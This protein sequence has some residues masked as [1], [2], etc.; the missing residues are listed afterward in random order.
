MPKKYE[1]QC[2]KQYIKLRKIMDMTQID[3]AEITGISLQTIRSYESGR[4]NPSVINME[5]MARAIGGT[6]LGIDGWK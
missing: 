1:L 5:M 2:V 6:G 4:R 3:V